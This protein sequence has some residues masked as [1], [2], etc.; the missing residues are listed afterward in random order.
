[1]GDGGET[2]TLPPGC[3]GKKRKKSR[4]E[5][6]KTDGVHLFFFSHLLLT[7]F[8]FGSEAYLLDQLFKRQHTELYT[9][10]K[11]ITLKDTNFF[12]SEKVD[13]LF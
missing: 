3:N 11:H 13:Y 10:T 5:K 7:A 9:I 1:M 12:Y 4:R 8:Y 6:Y 2:G